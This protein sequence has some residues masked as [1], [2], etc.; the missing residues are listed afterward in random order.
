MRETIAD[1]RPTISKLCMVIVGLREAIPLPSSRS[2]RKTSAVWIFRSDGATPIRR[3]FVLTPRGSDPL[4]GK[5]ISRSVWPSARMTDC[6][7]SRWCRACR[8]HRFTRREA[9][10]GSDYVV[11][12]FD[13]LRNLTWNEHDKTLARSFSRT[14]EVREEVWPP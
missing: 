10:I 12:N 5:W 14:T 2:G 4:S 13:H 9:V 7:I 8:L 11:E 6:E 1:F 3:C